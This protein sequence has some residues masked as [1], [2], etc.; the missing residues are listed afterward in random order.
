MEIPGVKIG[1]AKQLLKASFKRI[2]DV[3]EAKVDD[4]TAAIQFLSSKQALNL[5]DAAK[6]IL[7]NK[8]E[9]LEEDAAELKESKC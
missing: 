1:R 2:A 9:A 5:I 3:A 4:L 7:R 6:M 8:I